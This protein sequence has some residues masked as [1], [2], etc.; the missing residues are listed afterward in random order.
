MVGSQTTKKSFPYEA[1]NKKSKKK[2]HHERKKKKRKKEK[3]KK[4]KK[5][6]E[7]GPETRVV[8]GRTRGMCSCC[9]RRGFWFFDPDGWGGTERTERTGRSEMPERNKRTRRKTVA[10]RAGAR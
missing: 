1:E 4:R 10:V 8:R 9:A 6:N 7:A 2:D 5:T 3:K